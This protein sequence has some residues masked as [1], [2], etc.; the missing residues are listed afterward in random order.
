MNAGGTR[1]SSS[2]SAG[3]LARRPERAAQLFGQ[4]ARAVTRNIAPLIT[5]YTTKVTRVLRFLAVVAI[6]VLIGYVVFQ[7]FA[8]QSLFDWLGD[9]ID[10]LTDDAA[11]GARA[12]C[13]EGDDLVLGRH[14]LGVEPGL[15]LA[16]VVEHAWVGRPGAGVV[17]LHDTGL[18]Q[19][20]AAREARLIGG[21]HHRPSVDAPKRP[22]VSSALAS[23][24][25]QMHR[26]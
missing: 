25:T 11:T 26:S 23:A 15:Q 3:P 2:R 9:R 12:F 18:D 14:V 17:H 8:Q 21:V 24:C 19:L 4:Q 7:V 16:V 6:I 5:E 22:A 13:V 1:R 20:L 10:N